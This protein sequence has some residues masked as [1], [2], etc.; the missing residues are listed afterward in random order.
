MAGVAGVATGALCAAGTAGGTG[1]DGSF[2]VSGGLSGAVRQEN[3]EAAAR[4]PRTAKERMLLFAMDT[5]C[6]GNRPFYPKKLNLSRPLDRIKR[7]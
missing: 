5:R 1:P 2:A 6:S 3:N 7:R 4:S